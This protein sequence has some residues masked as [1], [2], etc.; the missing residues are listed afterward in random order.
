MKNIFE[1]KTDV[2]YPNSEI[3]QLYYTDSKGIPHQNEKCFIIPFITEI[4]H[5]NNIILFLDNDNN[6]TGGQIGKYD[7]EN[8][9][10]CFLFDK[11][12]QPI[13]H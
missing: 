2:F 12:Y 8:G 1:V 3:A 10:H 11:T 7:I 5:A 4:K 6:I 9:L 13:K